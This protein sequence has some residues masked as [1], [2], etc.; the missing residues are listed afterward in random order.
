MTGIDWLD[1]VIVAV[2]AGVVLGLL[3]AGWSHRSQ[4]ATRAREFWQWLWR[5]QRPQLEQLVIKKAEE[6]DIHVPVSKSGGLPVRIIYSNGVALWF[7]PDAG[8][9][10]QAQSEEPPKI[11]SEWKIPEL[12]A[13]LER[14]QQPG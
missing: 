4:L 12:R 6:T 7:D 5:R 8:P 1:G 10:G 2:L 13:F 9:G 11:V 3:R 14:G